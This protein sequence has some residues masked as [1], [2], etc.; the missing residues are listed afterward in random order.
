VSILMLLVACSDQPADDSKPRA[1]RAKQPHIL[2]V[3]IDTLR[4]DHVSGYGYERRTT[5]MLDSFAEKGVVFEQAYSHSPKTAP[6]HMS[7][8]T[9]LYPEAH[10]VRQLSHPDSRRLSDAIPTLASLLQEAGYRTAAITA[11][12][13]V[14]PELGFDRG[15][16]SFQVVRDIEIL[17]QSAAV[18]L[19]AMQGVTAEREPLFLFVHT[20]EVH[21]P[22]MPK[23]PYLDMWR[24]PNYA[25]RIPSSLTTLGDLGE[26]ED[27][28]FQKSHEFFWSRVDREDPADTQQLRDLYD[29]S[30]RQ[31]DSE[32]AMLIAWLRGAKML[33]ETLIIVLS[34][35]GE[36]FRDH[37]QFLH[38]RLYQEHLHVPLVMV[39]PR[40]DRARTKGQRIAAPVR[41]V[42]VAPTLLDY[43]KL[44]VPDGMQGESLMPLI[45]GSEEPTDRPVMS[46]YARRGYLALRDGRWKLV[47]RQQPRLDG[48]GVVT[49]SELYDL[50]SDPAE[51]LDLADQE[52]ERLAEL[53]ARA[54]ELDQAAK[55]LYRGTEAGERTRPDAE[56][57]EALRA[58]G[59][60]E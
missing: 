8:M 59:Y 51:R 50:E 55:A 18:Q 42:D 19:Q 49:Q 38:S 28:L 32:L 2:L 52:A 54:A 26:N 33:R 1:Q 5:P 10:G 31:V 21:D 30:I 7:L 15:I 41:L 34:D 11:G 58:L 60:V 36:E 57:L 44:P 53:S 9:S 37:G 43:L 22:Y 4:A 14:S 27:A 17:M 40:R 48:S 3:S 24:D 46:S 29:G 56:T 39:F 45:L 6:S 12:G 23:V 16:H 25:G 47:Q 20:Y 35:H 13:N